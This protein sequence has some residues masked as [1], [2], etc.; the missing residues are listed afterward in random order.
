[1]AKRILFLV[2]YPIDKAPSQRLK[3]EQY[4]RHFEA[5]GYQ[6]RHSAFISGAFWKII[7]QQ[8]HL[9][10][11]A[12]FTIGGYLRRTADLF[13]LWRYDV[14]YVHLWATP[15]GFPVYEWLLCLLSKRVIYDI[16]DL[17]YLADSKSKVNGLVAGLKGRNK[18]IYLMRR[19]DHV[20][21]CTPYLDSFVKKY[22]K[23]T[24]DISSTIDTVKYRPR[25]TYTFNEGVP[26]LGWSGSHSTSKYLHLLEPVFRRLKEEG[27]LF[28]LLV[29]G[30]EKF[31]MPG[32][33]VEALPWKEEYETAVI[34]RFDIGLYPLPDEEWVYGKSGLKA[35][36]YMGAGI[37]TIA[38]AIGANY[39]IMQEGKTGFLA[40]SEQDW[41][42][43][44]RRLLADQSLREKTGLAGAAFVQAHF[45]VEANKD[46]YL[47]ILNGAG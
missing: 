38:T 27:I 1:M 29:M 36:Q 31:S 18:P 40:R 13:R 33:E 47:S 39:R 22:N 25:T 42:L 34:G 28:K 11:K 32:I 15:F 8:G 2:P 14:V 7:Y 45:S 19:A 20:I 6:L 10:Q 4:Y 12:L 3:F 23:N 21:T 30:D 16:D 35:L 26:V 5:A 41:F 37:P 46:I 43:L 9:L 44:I 17:V 24:T